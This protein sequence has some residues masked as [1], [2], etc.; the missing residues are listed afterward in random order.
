MIKII[1]KISKAIKNVFAKKSVV[2]KVAAVTITVVAG[3]YIGITFVLP[4][5]LTLAGISA[6]ELVAYRQIR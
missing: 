1:K 5:L 6:L 2:R 3:S 4:V